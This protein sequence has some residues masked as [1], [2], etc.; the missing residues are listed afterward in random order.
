MENEEREQ[1]KCVEMVVLG[2]GLVSLMIWAGYI[3][4]AQIDPRFSFHDY[5]LNR[6]IFPSLKQQNGPSLVFGEWIR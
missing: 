1:Q 3:S 2:L 5:K 4:K 6:T